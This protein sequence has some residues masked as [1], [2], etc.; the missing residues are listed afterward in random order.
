MALLLVL[1]IVTLLTAI[2]M[3]LSY[4]TLIEQRLTET[5]RDSTRAYS[6][7]RGGITAGQTLITSDNNAYDAPSESWGSGIS[8]YPVGEGFISLA[9]ED[10]GGKIAINTLVVGNNP[11]TVAVDRFYRLLAALEVED[12]GELTAAVIDWL[13]SGDTPYQQI[14]T[15]DLE[16][17]VSGAENIYYQSL[18]TPYTC[19][20]GSMDSLEELLLVKGFTPEVFKL[21]SPYL[22]ADG[23]E[24][25][26][27]N[28]AEAPV[29]MSLSAD[30]SEQTIELIIDSRG[31]SP[32]TTIS[33]L[34]T[35][36]GEDQFSLIKTLAN[37]GLLGTTSSFYKITAE[38]YINDGR[39]ALETLF[40]KS[41]KSLSYI[42]TI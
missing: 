40:D 39:C 10:L 28:T 1:I 13:D 34:Q 15:D 37:Q 36:L 6:L 7:A 25:V 23:I 29:L 41:S 5:F 27:I 20:N 32:I 19:K 24:L 21:V 9:I 4:S 22:S 17:T 12:P 30:M 11:Q 31:N 8:S 16:L 38:A 26:N 33:A 2:M 42:R 35:L 3:E 18:A 14:Q